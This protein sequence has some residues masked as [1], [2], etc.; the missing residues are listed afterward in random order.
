MLT[1]SQKAARAEAAATAAATRATADYTRQHLELVSNR[2][3]QAN[4][5]PGFFPPPEQQSMTRDGAGAGPPT[6]PHPLVTQMEPLPHEPM[7]HHHGQQPPSPA[8]SSSGASFHSVS[9]GS[10][11]HSPVGAAP[12]PVLGR[13][14]RVVQQ[15]PPVAVGH[16]SPRSPM[17]RVKSM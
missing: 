1:S 17:R 16:S 11:S 7:V 3:N 15:A 4:P 13:A 6:P 8:G 14:V 12:M 10:S 5:H 9:S 2:A